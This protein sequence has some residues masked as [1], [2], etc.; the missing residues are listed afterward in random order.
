MGFEV[1][2]DFPFIPFPQ[3][4]SLI[5]PGDGA[6][7]DTCVAQACRPKGR[8]L[9]SPRARLL[10][11]PRLLWGDDSWRG[12]AC[13]PGSTGRH[14]GRK[15]RVCFRLQTVECEEGSEDDESLR[16]MVE[17]AAQRLYEALTPVHWR[18]DSSGSENAFSYAWL[19]FC[20]LKYIS[21]LGVA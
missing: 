14:L 19:N 4:V 18:R 8:S 13:L 15:A 20:Y 17:L 6:V 11:P 2:I 9:G 12:S 3:S 10:W 16:E 7:G 21:F 5:R 1:N